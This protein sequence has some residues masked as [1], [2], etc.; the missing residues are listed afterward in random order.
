MA[1]RFDEHT[2]AA[3]R[4]RRARGFEARLFL[5]VDTRDGGA[6]ALAGR[7]AVFG[8]DWVPS[9]RP[10]SV[11]EARRVEG[12]LVFVD[13]RIAAQA[14]NA[15]VLISARHL[16]PIERLRVEC[17]ESPSIVDMSYRPRLSVGRRSAPSHPNAAAIE[18]R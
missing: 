13:S 16:G 8:V 15:D 3:I 2:R 12:V 4:R 6:G 10:S 14:D 1:I 7:P 5:Y 11:F 18:T 17:P 9:H